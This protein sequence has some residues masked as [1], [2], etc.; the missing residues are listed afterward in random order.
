MT[1]IP[2]T[3]VCA[4]LCGKVLVKDPLLLM[5]I[6]NKQVSA[7]NTSKTLTNVSIL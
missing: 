4:A 7:M 1:G 5:G 6:K 3:M 2:E